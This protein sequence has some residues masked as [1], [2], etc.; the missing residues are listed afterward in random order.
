[1][2]TVLSIIATLSLVAFVVGMFSP[3]TVKCSSRGKVALIFIGIFFVSTLIV[4]AL[5]EE[6][7]NPEVVKTESKETPQDS[8]KADVKSEE[9]KV[10]EPK[11]GQTVQVGN[12]AYQV[13]DVSFKKRVGN[14]FLQ[15]TADGIYLLIDLAL[16]N[17]DD[18]AHTLD[19]SFF[20]VTDSEGREYEHS[21]NGSTALEM[22]GYK[23]LFLKQCQP[24][25]TTR[26]VL[27][28]EV[29]KKDTYY[30]HLTGGAWSTKTL[31]ILLS[32]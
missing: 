29:P 3:K 1:M 12:F 19:A 15:E 18:E 20:S 7:E 16:M 26:G 27:I 5:S 17:I 6:V 9:E 25:V 23:T 13:N 10:E 14:E 21:I 32:K 24:N 30:L 4:G 8:T 2:E 28:F 22:S 11:I 31:R